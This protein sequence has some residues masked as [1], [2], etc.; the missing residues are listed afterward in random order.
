VSLGFDLGDCSHYVCVLDAAGQIR[1]E[2]TLVN[3]RAAL[4][5][6]LT[7]YPAAR[8]VVGIYS[9]LSGPPVSTP[10]I[11]KLAPTILPL[12]SVP[13]LQTGAFRQNRRL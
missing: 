8:N 7:Q 6:L 4:T 13:P 12:A 9:D 1:H 5:L 3:D 2:G 11:H 10:T